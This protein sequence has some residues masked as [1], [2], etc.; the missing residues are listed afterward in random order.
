M[1]D[2]VKRSICYNQNIT[3][4]INDIFADLKEDE[5]SVAC[6]SQKMTE[7]NIKHIARYLSS[8]Q[9]KEIC[10]FQKVSKEYIEELRNPIKVIREHKETPKEMFVNMLRDCINDLESEQVIDIIECYKDYVY[11]LEL[12]E[13]YKDFPNLE[14]TLEGL[15]QKNLSDTLEQQTIFL[16]NIRDSIK[17]LKN[18]YSIDLIDYFINTVNR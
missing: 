14:K 11:F 13:T 17:Q 10:Y 18:H 2:N 5:K 12:K 8:S 9:I 4:I 15:I 6:C 3:H 16:E 1:P 7:D